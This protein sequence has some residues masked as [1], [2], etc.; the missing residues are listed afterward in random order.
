M[1]AYNEDT[2]L[3][4][5]TP[6][7]IDMAMEFD[8]IGVVLGLAIYNS[9]ILDVH[10]PPVLF[11]KLLGKQTVFEDLEGVSLVNGYS[12]CTQHRVTTFT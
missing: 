8:L 6:T 4:W 10:F 11:K 7:D 5:F 1:F 2:R 12:D 3:F 9:H